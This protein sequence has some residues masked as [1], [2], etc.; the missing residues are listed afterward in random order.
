MSTDAIAVAASLLALA[1]Q[2]AN[3]YLKISILKEIGERETALRKEIDATY[4]RKDVCHQI[5]GGIA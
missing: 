3:A 1:G 5:H 2:V 4:M